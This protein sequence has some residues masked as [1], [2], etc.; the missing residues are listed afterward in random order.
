M[1]KVPTE[2]ALARPLIGKMHEQGDCRLMTPSDDGY[3]RF[4][5]QVRNR[6][7]LDKLLNELAKEPT[8][9]ELIKSDREQ[10]HLLYEK[11][12][13]HNAFTGR[14]GS[15]FAYEGLGSIYW[16]M[17]SKLMLAALEV[18]LDKD[19]QHLQQSLAKS[20]YEIQCGLGFR[21]L[22][23]D[24]GAFPADA[25]SHTPSHSGA[26]QPG[27]TGMVKEGIICRFLELGV[28]F[29]QGCICFSP[30]I[31]RSAELSTH[32]QAVEIFR[33]KGTTETIEIPE[34]SILFTFAQTPVIYQRNQSVDP[35]IKVYFND[36]THRTLQSDTL[37]PEL[38]EAI[39]SRNNSIR[40]IVVQQPANRF[41][42]LYD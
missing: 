14:S 18:T 16:H 7:E 15:M 12:F 5:S 40:H 2:E 27:L 6:F 11:T 1:N 19:N 3:M 4:S 21:Q 34:E 8:L 20:Y 33:E 25:Y 38:S 26:C 32:K 42:E 35:Q 29:N 41:I 24:Y 10:I 31:L 30:I 39:I 17:V 36:G 13:N 28:N 9:V 23:A 37:D 22:P